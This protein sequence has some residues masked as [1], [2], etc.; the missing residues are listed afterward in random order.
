MSPNSE[1]TEQLLGK[2]AFEQAKIDQVM[3]SMAC[4][5][6]RI[7]NIEGNLCGNAVSTTSAKDLFWT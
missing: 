6:A 4:E 7:R 5:S 1:V 2:T 3:T